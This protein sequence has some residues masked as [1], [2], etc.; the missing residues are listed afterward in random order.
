MIIPL[1]LVS[2]RPCT[3][4]AAVKMDSL[5]LLLF[6]RAQCSLAATGRQLYDLLCFFFSG[7]KD[8][9]KR[10]LGVF[11]KRSLLHCG[12]LSGRKPTLRGGSGSRQVVYANYYYAYLRVLT[13]G[14][15]SFN[16]R[17]Q[18]GKCSWSESWP[19]GKWSRIVFVDGPSGTI[20]RILVQS[21]FLLL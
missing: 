18:R 15:P 3:N 5:S 13:R 7:P 11:Y 19:T 17:V 9:K 12:T 14:P 10:D 6:L 1:S 21:T 2:S 4:V 8:S 16:R 20:C